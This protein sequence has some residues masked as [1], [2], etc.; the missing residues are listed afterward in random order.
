[1][2]ILLLI[3][4]FTSYIALIERILKT[5]AGI[6]LI[7]QIEVGGVELNIQAASIVILC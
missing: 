4:P 5:E 1:M 7:S 3:L 6:V 2:W